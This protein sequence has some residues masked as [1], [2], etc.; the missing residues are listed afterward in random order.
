MNV[1][2]K[3][4]NRSVPTYRGC[5]VA[6]GLQKRQNHIFKSRTTPSGE[7]YENFNFNRLTAAN[8]HQVNKSRGPQN[9]GG[10]NT[11]FKQTG[12]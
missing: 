9:L 5:I 8:D 4:I 12:Q 10:L 3:L 7:M 6:K 1:I 2:A 11:Q